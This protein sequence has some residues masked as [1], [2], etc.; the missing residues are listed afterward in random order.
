MADESVAP[1]KLKFDKG[2]QEA[3]VGWMM[4]DHAFL[5]QCKEYIPHHYFTDPV[6][7]DIAKI[8]YAM[9]GEGMPT[10]AEVQAQFGGHKYEYAD[11]QERLNAVSQCMAK[12]QNLKM[13]RLAPTLTSFIKYIVLRKALAELT[14]RY[15]SG[16]YDDAAS[17]MKEQ[18][19]KLNR[20][21][22]GKDITI[23]FNDTAE[24]IQQTMSKVKDNCCTIG[25][26][27]FDELLREGSKKLTNENTD[28]K[29]IY[30]LTHGGL[31]PADTT[32][33]MGPSNS[34]KSTT[35]TSIIAENLCLGKKVLWVTAEQKWQDHK[36]RIIQ[37]VGWFDKIKHLSYID[38][39]DI[40]QMVG[41]A[42]QTLQNLIYFPWI[43]TDGMFVE[44]VIGRIELEQEKM[45]TARW[46]ERVAK[47]KYLVEKGL[48]TDDIDAQLLKEDT[49]N[50]GFDLVV[51]DYPAKFQAKSFS[52]RK[53]EDHVE[54]T[55]VYNQFVLAALFHEWHTVLPVQTNREGYKLSQHDEGRLLDQ[56]DVAGAFNIPAIASNVISINRTPSDVEANRVKYHI[57]K[58]RTSKTHFT[59]VSETAFEVGRT[60]GICPT[61]EKMLHWA[62]YKPG[63]PMTDELIS[64]ALGDQKRKTNVLTPVTDPVV[65]SASINT[66][67]PP[68]D[69]PI[70][71]TQPVPP[72]DMNP[73]TGEVPMEKPKT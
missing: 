15:N 31:E 29:F 18:M 10:V 2:T 47:R 26:P 32:L 64:Q 3:I 45:Q 13:E 33:I 72:A 46:N 9:P 52:T 34:G 40:K 48:M 55:F 17:W 39:P 69:Q 73:Q 43:K 42:E 53:A 54:K 67:V 70:F 63:A 23:K 68:K 16:Q 12:R 57:T 59:F 56:G 41:F 71:G 5:L 44:D 66:V 36:M 11:S 62:I 65:T 21:Q 24:F 37:A 28:R 25:H 61:M 19:D 6:L 22:F 58:C 1:D 35:V 14:R 30:N 7:S 50:R 8:I 27:E 38:R 20:V 49:A 51:V 4:S 60:H